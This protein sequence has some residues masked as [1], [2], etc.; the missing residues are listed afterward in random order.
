MNKLGFY[1]QNSQGVHQW[2]S[3]VQPPVMLIHAWDQGLLKEIRQSRSPNTFM[4]G[5]MD[6]IH[7]DGNKQP[8]TQNLINQWLDGGDPAG[9]GRRLAEHILNDNFQL[10]QQRE[11][12]RL[13]VDAWMSINEPIP[14][15]ASGAFGRGGAEREEIERRLRAYDRFQVAFRHTLMEHGIEAV[16]FNF[17]AGNF[18]QPEHYLDYFEGTLDSYTYLGFHE[19]GWPALSTEVDPGAVSSAGSY[20]PIIKG[21]RGK[22]GRSYKAIMTEAGLARMFKHN[23]GA[24]DV[25]WLYPP[26]SIGQEHYWR[27]LDW[28]N[29][30]LVQDDFALGACLF[31]VG[32]GAGWETFRH[33]GQD[34]DSHPIEIL[35]RVKTL[36]D[37]VHPLP[38][39]TEDPVIPTVQP[40]QRLDLLDNPAGDEEQPAT[41][42]PQI[43]TPAVQM[44]QVIV[45]QKIGIDANRPV[46]PDSGQVD[47]RLGDPAII[48]DTGAGWVRIN[49]V[50]GPA[51]S[52]PQDPGFQ[53]TYMG[54][55][56]GLRN[57]GI[58][59]YGLIGHEAMPDQPVDQLRGAPPAGR[60][61]HEWIDRYVQTY[62]QIARI[63]H[64]RVD[65]FEA[66]NEPDDFHGGGDNWIHPGWF[67]V[68]MQALHTQLRAD[69]VTRSVR[70]VSGPLQGLHNDDEHHNGNGGAR[71]LRKMYQEGKA[72]YGWGSS[73]PFP[74]DGVG[75][76]LYVAQS[77]AS[78]NEKIRQKYDEYMSEFRQ[79]IGEEEGAAK[80][81]YLSEFGWMSNFG[82]EDFQMRAMQLGLDLALNDPSLALVIWFS[83]QDF[84]PEDNHKFYGLYRKGSLDAGNRK[85]IYNLF[86]TICAQAKE[87]PVTTTTSIPTPISP[88]VSDLPPVKLPRIYT[89]QQ[90][91]DAFANAAERFKL[92]QWDL[93]TR[94]GFNVNELAQARSALF[95]GPSPAQ[96]MALTSVERAVVT[97]E[98]LGELLKKVRWVGLITASDGLNLRTGP[99]DENALIDSIPHDELVQVLHEEDG[100]LFVMWH[101]KP[102]YVSATWVTQR[103]SATPV[104][105]A[106]PAADINTVLR[107][108]WETHHTLFM[109]ESTRLGI[110]PAIALAVLMAESGGRTAA[111]DGRP[112]IRFEV[113]VFF[114][115]WGF[116]NPE[117]FGRFFEFD[118][119]ERWKGHR[120]RRRVEDPFQA[121]HNS[122][123]D[124]W[125]V[126]DFARS[127]HEELTL[128][129]TSIGAAQIMG[130]NYELAGYDSATAMFKDFQHSPENQIRCFF[131][132]IAGRG[133]DEALRRNDFL[134]FASGYN[135]SGQAE[136]YR[137]IILRYLERVRAQIPEVAGGVRAIG[138]DDIPERLPQPLGPDQLGGKTLAEVDLALYEAWRSHIQQGFKNN[139]TMFDSVLNGFMSPYWTTVWMYRALFVVGILSFVAAIVLA[140]VTQDNPTTAIGGAAVFGAVGVLAFL[141]FF[142]SRPL[143]ALEENLQLITW[144]GIIYNTYWTRMA[145]ISKLETVQED[146]DAASSKTVEQI[147]ELLDKHAELSGKRPGLR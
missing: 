94:A 97:Q 11:S 106:A 93:L 88:K 117:L 8:I 142:L 139:Q 40:P 46:D 58:Q 112:I 26:D 125:A 49:F 34:N 126:L 101:G 38:V 37:K 29:D 17:G 3:E 102:G 54:I 75:Y 118:P 113:H 110:D 13:L 140:Y 35:N 81:I 124:E 43:D 56:D 18:T 24:G 79:V 73:A 84:D 44:E 91:I 71:Y 115:Q 114:D 50:I 10:A 136:L 144:L 134:A 111:A 52:G 61:Q 119:N 42:A 57:R 107:Q 33:I 87:V 98:L 74:F 31:Q 137:G 22:T 128:R 25:G 86:R 59:I 28:F 62:V 145:Y 83:T 51:W 146:I 63:F 65:V 122:Q 147:K 4:I 14:G 27:S 7:F 96:M 76:H 20:R 123:A 92:G 45:R 1:T 141:S 121:C 90:I 16:A 15:P 9:A 68:L 32:H 108:V 82:N 99:G 116:Q 64:D 89:D 19:Y 138:P 127:M 21:I 105:P 12:G 2:I 36:R 135:G 48:A 55:L 39:E 72:R 109:D 77:P 47:P 100:W 6:Y 41:M 131:R 53:Q 30:Y 23:D 103:T 120:W 80:P 67:A 104:T 5:R 60:P 129:S 70:L 85:P 130:F 143:Q 69:P 132:Y 66:Y 133:I 78:S 95:N